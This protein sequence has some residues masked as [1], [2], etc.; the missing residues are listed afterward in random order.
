MIHRSL[1]GE[2]A[3]TWVE[4]YPARPVSELLPCDEDHKSMAYAALQNQTFF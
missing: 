2:L 4:K 3:M 1:S